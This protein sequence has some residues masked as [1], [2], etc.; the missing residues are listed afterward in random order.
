MLAGLACAVAA[1]V[2]GCTSPT[3]GG[4]EIVLLGLSDTCRPDSGPAPTVDTLVVEVLA[5]PSEASL[6]SCRPCPGCD[7]RATACRCT[8]V[9]E[10][11]LPELRRAIS[12][13]ALGPFDDPEQDDYCIRVRALQVGHGLTGD[14]ECDPR[15]LETEQP[16]AVLCGLSRPT[17]LVEDVSLGVTGL[18]CRPSDNWRSCDQ[19]LGSP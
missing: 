17:R 7:R 6:T 11:A 15:W 2:N 9:S 18:S 1:W 10:A 13:L 12:G 14:C 5:A 19:P 8:V 4:G 3:A 16:E